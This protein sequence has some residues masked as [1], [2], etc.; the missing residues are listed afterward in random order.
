LVADLK[1]N[2]NP[3]EAGVDFEAL[4]ELGV[5]SLWQATSSYDPGNHAG[6]IRPTPAGCDKKCKKNYFSQDNDRGNRTDGSVDHKE[7]D[8]GQP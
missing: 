3:A 7:Q 5:L 8:H 4:F 1:D 2:K 6:D